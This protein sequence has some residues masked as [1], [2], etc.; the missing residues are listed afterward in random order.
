MFEPF[1]QA[2]KSTT[3]LVGGLGL[4]LAIVKQIV[5]LHG[6]AVTATSAGEGQGTTITLEFP[7]PAVL[8]EPDEPIAER[9]QQ[10]SAGQRL[11][12]IRVLVVDDEREACEA[13]RV[14]LEDH[15]AAVRIATSAT[16][17]L[18]LIAD[19]DPHAIIADLAMPEHDGY[20]LIREV[21]ARL[22]SRNVPAVALTAY[23]DDARGPALSA[24]FHQFSSKPIRPQDLV[25]LVEQLTDST[26]VH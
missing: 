26:R 4:G 11:A 13:V 22:G 2:D 10:T 3:R 23:T 5:T 12:G 8:T 14:V 6:G 18:E 19:A 24:G 16:E 9:E 20:E 21:R 17:A 7:I 15:G 25:T 1:A